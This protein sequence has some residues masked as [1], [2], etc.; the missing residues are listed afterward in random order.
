MMTTFTGMLPMLSFSVKDSVF[1]K[2]V[3]PGAGMLIGR[4]LFFIGI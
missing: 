2:S 1:L 4:L 3:N